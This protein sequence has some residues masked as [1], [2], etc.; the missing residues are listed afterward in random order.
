MRTP[1]VHL[2]LALVV[3]AAGCSS[4][5][6]SFETKPVELGSPDAAVEEVDAGCVGLVCSR[7]LRSVHDCHGKVV[8]ECAAD[9]ACGKGV[10]IDPCEAAASNEGSVG[11]SFAIPGA[12]KPE[13]TGSC[14]AFFVANDWTSPA[15]I[16]VTHAGGE[17]PLDGAVWVPYVEDGEVKHAKHEGPIPPGRAAVV[18]LSNEETGSIRNWVRC[19]LGVKPVF[20]KDLSVQ[21]TAR[22][23]AVFATADVPVSMYSIYPYGG[24]RS[25]IPSGTLLLPTTSFRK[26]Y[27]AVSS[28]GGNGDRF[29]E[30]VIVPSNRQPQS[31]A[32]TLQIVAVEDD[33][34]VELLPRV[35]IAGGGGIAPSAASRVASFRLQR[36]EVLQ[37]VQQKE[38]VGSIV[39]SSKPVGMFGG[40]TCMRVPLGDVSYCDSDNKQIP[41]L[42]AWGHEYAVMP[43]PDR[44]RLVNGRGQRSN[45][46]SV[47]RLVGAANGTRLVYEPARPANAPDTLESGQLARF[48]ASE[49]FVVRSQD[50]GHPFYAA[51]VMT[52]QMGS[53]SALGDP[54]TAV[55][56]PTD[57][58]L[59]TYGFVSDHTFRHS[60][61]YVTRR[62]SH[63]ALHDVTLD[64]AG[65]LTGWEPITADYEWTYVEL[66]RAKRPQK[67]PGGTCTDGAHRIS[68][69]GPFT[70][71]VWGISDAASYSYQGG[72]GLRRA[73]ELYLPVR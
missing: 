43:A 69:A 21:G 33:T 6:T 18:F 61:V 44:V 65:V 20:T 36:G 39:E 55:G 72:T 19:P 14:T 3:G 73:T 9:K 1:F 54:E 67:Y 26:N 35:E 32:P 30:G 17:Q 2:L 38:L 48:F 66:T 16:R 50:A 12:I 47:I 15:T 58:W 25:F 27:V 5:R 68:S 70:I 37:L 71:A 62:R 28:W 11:C 4:D 29:G 51:S 22:G 8:K 41:P 49:P 42:S 10:C 24:A 64:C 63:G 13:H 23:T 56:V 59:D 46:L 31:G 34:S 45:E 7:D 52:G 60:A 40:H 57:Q 53:K